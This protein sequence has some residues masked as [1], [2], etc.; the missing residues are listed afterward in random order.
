MC[1]VWI[2][3]LPNNIFHA[4]F[5]LQKFSANQPFGRKIKEFQKHGIPSPIFAAKKE[6]HE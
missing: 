4:I 3:Y 1:L 5:L 2:H 6:F